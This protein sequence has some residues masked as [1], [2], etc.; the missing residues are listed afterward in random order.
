[1]GRENSIYLSTPPARMSAEPSDEISDAAFFAG[2]EELLDAETQ[3]MQAELN[4]LSAM[5]AELS[6]LVE[7]EAWSQADNEVFDLVPDQAPPV[8]DVIAAAI[9][10]RPTPIVTADVWRPAPVTSAI[11]AHQ[12]KTD[13]QGMA[14]FDDVEQ[15][16][17]KQVELS[18]LVA[19]SDASVG[20]NCQSGSD[21]RA[22]LSR[23]CLPRVRVV[24]AP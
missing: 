3:R 2:S 8:H 15:F 24:W 18:S 5:E 1:M 20:R 6:Q 9:A 12:H 14:E 19:D 10:L 21:R 16:M 23:S 22:I 7:V 17:K 13:L 4:A 11:H